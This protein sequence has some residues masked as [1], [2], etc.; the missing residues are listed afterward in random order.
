MLNKILNPFGIVIN[1]DGKPW[2][3]VGVLSSI[4]LH[5]SFYFTIFHFVRKVW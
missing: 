3:W 2:I 5:G 4:I 1:Y